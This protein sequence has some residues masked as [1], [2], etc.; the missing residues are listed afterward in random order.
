MLGPD[1][2]PH[3]YGVDATGKK[4]QD[5]SVAPQP[6]QAARHTASELAQVERETRTAIRKADADYRQAEGTAN[7]QRN[8]IAEAKGENK[9][10]VK[11]VP[12]EG[13]LEITTSQGVHRINRTEVEQYGSPGSILDHIIGKLHGAV[14]GQDIPD[15]VLDDMDKMTQQVIKNAQQRYSDT[16]DDEMGIAQGYGLALAKKMPKI[17]PSAGGNQGQAG[18]LPPAWK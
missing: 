1:N 3:V 9:A 16:Y 5:F 6:D 10:T 4:V 12:L 15:W 7:L 18:A 13:A 14:Q 17:K 2:K 11:I 8:F